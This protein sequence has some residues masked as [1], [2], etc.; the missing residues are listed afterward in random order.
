MSKSKRKAH[1]PL[2]RYQIQAE[3]ALRG[4]ALAMALSVDDA[5][6]HSFSLKTAKRFSLSDTAINALNACAFK[7]SFLLYVWSVESNGK[8][9][10]KVEFT[11]MASRYN[12]LALVEFLREAHLALVESE[13]AKGNIVREA[14]WVA[15]PVTKLD[16]EALQK[17][18]EVI[19]AEHHKFNKTGD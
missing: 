12:H 4:T 13:K 10:I 19:A 2:K 1:N 6:I 18:M 5:H 8:R 17:A 11:K 3:G 14:G 9:R 16:D 15:V 7:W